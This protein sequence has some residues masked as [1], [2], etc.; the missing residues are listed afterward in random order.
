MVNWF[1]E[2]VSPCITA[3][4]FI[5][6]KPNKLGAIDELKRQTNLLVELGFTFSRCPFRQEVFHGL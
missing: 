5:S 4:T 1:A 3:G 2:N 6:G